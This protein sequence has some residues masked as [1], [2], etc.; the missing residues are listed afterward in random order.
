MNYM[1]D[2][3]YQATSTLCLHSRSIVKIALRSGES[4]ASFYSAVKGSLLTL[5][6]VDSSLFPR[7]DMI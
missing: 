5:E 6:E 3:I 2:T 1:T 4:Y 7:E